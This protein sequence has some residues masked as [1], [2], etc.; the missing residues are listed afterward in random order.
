MYPDARLMKKAD[1][2]SIIGYNSQAAVDC[3]EHGLIVAAEVSQ[4]ATDDNLLKE[5]ADK[6]EEETGV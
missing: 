6:A 2:K 3:G 5:I 1:G 4:D